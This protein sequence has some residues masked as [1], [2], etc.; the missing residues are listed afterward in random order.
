MYL[1]VIGLVC[2]AVT[3]ALMYVGTDDNDVPLYFG[4]F[5]VGSVALGALLFTTITFF[6]QKQSLPATIL[7]TSFATL[8][9]P[10]LLTIARFTPTYG[11]I[12]SIAWL[13]DYSTEF[14]TVVLL[15]TA[16][17]VVVATV[18]YRFVRGVIGP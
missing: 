3:V 8:I 9:L 11:I 14:T 12:G 1:T 15:Q 7:F 16:A 17:N 10:S 6:V 4:A 5:R 18:M 13:P 2:A